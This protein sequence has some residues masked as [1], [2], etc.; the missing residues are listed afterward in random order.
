M[1]RSFI[2]SS[3]WRLDRVAADADPAFNVRVMSEPSVVSVHDLDARRAA[4]AAWGNY[5]K[6]I[7]LISLLACTWLPMA[8]FLLSSRLEGAMFGYAGTRTLLL[9]LGTAHV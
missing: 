4:P 9:F 3:P 1:G 6:P 7:F 5:V 2:A 8:F